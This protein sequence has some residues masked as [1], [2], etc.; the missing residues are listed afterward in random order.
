MKELPAGQQFIQV[1]NLTQALAWNA[2]KAQVSLAVAY[3]KD[4]RFESEHLHKEFVF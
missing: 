3:R 4:N 2:R 1:Y